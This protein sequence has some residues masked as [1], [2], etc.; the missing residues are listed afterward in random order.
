MRTPGHT[1]GHLSLFEPEARVLLGG[2]L[3][4]A[5]DVAW[6]N[7]FR[8]G[9]LA[10]GTILET[11]DNVA[12]L[13]P[14]WACSRHGRPIA[15][16]LAALDAARRRYKGWLGAPERL[17]WHA[18]KKILTYALMLRGGLPCADL[19]TYLLAR[20]WFRDY[21]RYVFLVEPAAFARPLLDEMLRSGAAIAVGGRL[22][23][24]TRHRTPPLP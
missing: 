7:P 8:E 20:A 21:S 2:D 9:V 22:H 5:G 4:H 13:R 17:G 23:A 12:N 1:L 16:P 15:E 11:L 3:F 18:C 19:P 14:V 24:V 10:I 6:I